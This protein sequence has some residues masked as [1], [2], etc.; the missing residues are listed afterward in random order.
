M[1]AHGA[2]VTLVDPRE[3]APA[4]G[5]GVQVLR[6]YAI[7]KAKGRQGVTGARL[8]H[9]ATGKMHDQACDAIGMSGGWSPT[10]HLASHRGSKPVCQQGE[11]AFLAGTPAPGA[12]WQLAGWCLR[13]PHLGRNFGRGRAHQG[14][15][16]AQ[17]AGFKATAK[18]LKVEGGPES[19]TPPQRFWSVPAEHLGRTRAFI[20][21]Q[22]DVTTKDVKMAAQ[23]GFLSPEH[24]KRYTTLGMATDQGKLS[25]TVGHAL[26][27][28]A[29]DRPIEQVGT[30]TYRPPFTPVSIG[31]FAERNTDEAWMPVRRTPLAPW[32]EANGAL[33]MEAADWRRAWFYPRGIEDI[34]H[35][36]RREAFNTR[37]AVGI[38]DVSTLGK[39]D[40]RG[41][42]AGKLLDLAYINIMSSIKIGKA[43]YGVMLR[44]D[45]VILDDGTVSRLGDDHFFVTTTTAEAAEVM[46]HLEHLVQVEFPD[47]H[48]ILTSVTD[49]FGGMALAGP[50]PRRCVAATA[51]EELVSG[52]ALPFMGFVAGR[53]RRLPCAHPPHLLL[54][55]IGL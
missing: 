38:S 24:M 32:H 46:S 51:G 44:E 16:A 36:S 8:V 17:D 1:A 31:A 25:N 9:L 5:Q 23:E 40:V 22:H 33:F 18:K 27:A 20:D 12:D 50:I 26:L 47:L 3:E 14:A 54:W 48:V 53:N 49:C 39:I 13:H 19:L 52:E 7:A 42:D 55:G 11:S 43:R 15:R 30:T 41:P 10:I 28:E 4:A 37:Q 29:Q 21:F 35:A 2:E 6:G 45:G 34:T